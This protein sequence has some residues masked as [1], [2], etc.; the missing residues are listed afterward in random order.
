V[1]QIRLKGFEDPEGRFLVAKNNIIV[2]DPDLLRYVF[3]ARRGDYPLMMIGKWG[4]GKNVVLDL[5]NRGTK[6]KDHEFKDENLIGTAKELDEKYFGTQRQPGVIEQND[7]A[8]IHFDLMENL[9]D[10]PHLVDKLV[11]LVEQGEL[12]R[13]DRTV[14]HVDVRVIGGATYD[15]AS[16]LRRESRPIDADSIL[17]MLVDRLSAN[18]TIRTKQLAEIPERIPILISEQFATLYL[19]KLFTPDELS[20]MS[21]VPLG[22]LQTLQEYQWRDFGQFIKVIRGV[23]SSGIW[24]DVHKILQ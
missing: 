23:A 19:N 21:L 7:G 11:T 10:K 17:L 15:L 4:T 2:S 8:L 1:E 6:R 24:D 16:A 18:L 20:K 5:I 3:E 9:R 12:R 22:I 13:S 14:A